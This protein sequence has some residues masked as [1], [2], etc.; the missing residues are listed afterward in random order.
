MAQSLSTT[1]TSRKEA[2]VE[3]VTPTK[4]TPTSSRKVAV[5]RIVNEHSSAPKISPL[6]SSNREKN[7]MYKGNQQSGSSS[8]ST[9]PTLLPAPLP[10]VNPW[11]EGDSQHSTENTTPNT[12][13]TND[14]VDAHQY[15]GESEASPTEA[16]LSSPTELKVVD[17]DQSHQDCVVTLEGSPTPEQKGQM[18]CKSRN[19]VYGSPV[20][21]SEDDKASVMASSNATEDEDMVINDMTTVSSLDQSPNNKGL[22][23]AQKKRAARKIAKAAER[24][25]IIEEEKI[26][27]AAKRTVSQVKIERPTTPILIAPT[28]AHTPKL[29]ET[30][31]TFK[32]T[33]LNN[34]R[35]TSDTEVTK[36]ALKM[37]LA[38]LEADCEGQGAQIKAATDVHINSIRTA[39]RVLA[40]N[41]ELPGAIWDLRN[42]ASSRNAVHRSMTSAEKPL[43][44]SIF[45]MM[46]RNIDTS[47]FHSGKIVETRYLDGTELQEEDKTLVARAKLQYSSF[48]WCCEQFAF[49]LCAAVELHHRE[50]A[51]HEAQVTTAENADYPKPAECP[52]NAGTWKLSFPESTG[53]F[54]FEIP[55]P[56]SSDSTSSVSSFT[57]DF[58][59]SA[60]LPRCILEPADSTPMPNIFDVLQSRASS[61]ASSPSTAEDVPVNKEA[62]SKG[63]SSSSPTYGAES[64]VVH[65]CAPVEEVAQV[66][67]HAATI[68]SPEGLTE[69]NTLEQVNDSHQASL[70]E[71][72]S[73]EMPSLSA[74]MKGSSFADTPSYIQRFAQNVAAANL[75]LSN[76][77][78][79]PTEIIT[80]VIDESALTSELLESVQETLPQVLSEAEKVDLVPSNISPSISSSEVSEMARDYEMKEIGIFTLKDF[81]RVLKTVSPTQ[82]S[83]TQLAGAFVQLS[84]NERDEIDLGPAHHQDTTTILS[85][86]R[87]QHKIKLGTIKLVHF[88]QA[89]EFNL[90]ESASYDAIVKGL[91]DCADKDAKA[92]AEEIDPRLLRGVYGMI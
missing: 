26:F 13:S 61:R 91:L 38:K 41:T 70:I 56:R 73:E 86:K 1:P 9:S 78:T 90:N 54:N 12:M 10:K 50:K 49:S 37:T 32:V 5:L 36:V 29:S 85:N 2:A 7:S 76:N 79:K 28:P 18:M 74:I 72:V 42:I 59:K 4:N 31:P 82:A 17:E 15:F 33:A 39:G 87:L 45:A 58:T 47:A 53:T 62:V 77:S 21:T 65:D 48:A 80:D 52:V 22:T 30:V 23:K 64:L 83:K 43:R 69:S 89:I 88:L 67:D 34:L 51:C 66:E 68:E 27:Q 44:E 75:T 25:Q 35:E 84:N 6:K 24:R 8:R 16:K 3:A 57:D 71:V 40:K 81:F 55:R 60:S 14:D 63:V 46:R 11:G 92:Q 20:P 19:P